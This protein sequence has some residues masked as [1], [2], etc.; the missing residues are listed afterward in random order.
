ML[1]KF[2][3]KIWPSLIP[4][5]VYIFWVYVI[6]GIFIKK[7]LKRTKKK[8]ESLK[9]EFKFVG[10]KSTSQDLEE[11]NDEKILDSNEVGKFSL[12]N[13]CFMIMVYMSL[14]L[15]ILTLIANALSS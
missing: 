9:D 3:L 13:R 8:H 12:N 11:N 5:F 10:E 6:E 4:I 14:I 2:L 7:I 15:A 1:L